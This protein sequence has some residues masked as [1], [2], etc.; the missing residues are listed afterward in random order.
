M[1]VPVYIH[2]CVYVNIS[3]ECGVYMAVLAKRNRVHRKRKKR[4]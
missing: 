1:R 3:E 4:N 2:V